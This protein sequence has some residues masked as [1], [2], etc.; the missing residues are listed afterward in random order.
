MT[1]AA[2]MTG[3]QSSFGVIVPDHD[4]RN[5]VV[6]LHDVDLG[7]DALGIY[8]RSGERTRLPIPAGRY[9]VRAASGID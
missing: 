4:R 2:N 8:V 7:R 3:A 9:R 6:L 1:P 5:Y